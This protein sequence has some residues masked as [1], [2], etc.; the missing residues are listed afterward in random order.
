MPSSRGSSQPRDWTWSPA[1][2][3]GSLPAEPP[4]KPKN[5]TKYSFKKTLDVTHKRWR[6]EHRWVRDLTPQ[7]MH[8][9]KF[10]CFLFTLSITDWVLLKLAIQKHQRSQ[11]KKNKSLFSPAK[12]QKMGSKTENLLDKNCSTSTTTEKNWPQFTPVS[13]GRVEFRL[14]LL[15][16][17]SEVQTSPR[18][19]WRPCGLPG[20]GP[21]PNY[22]ESSPLMTKVVSKKTK[23]FIPA[24]W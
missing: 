21:L 15:H 11:T 9:N 20:L 1:L 13:K 3:A 8:S 2:Q 18:R 12:G 22:N 6:E 10:P 5:T 7:R 14:P 24:R 4:R 23:T 16:S 19:H 17:R